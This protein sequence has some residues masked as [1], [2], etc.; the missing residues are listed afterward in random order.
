M[1]KQDLRVFK[2]R[3]SLVEL[4]GKYL[5]LELH[6]SGIWQTCPACNGASK[7]IINND[8]TYKCMQ[9]RCDLHRSGDIFNLF[10][11]KGHSFKEACDILD[12]QCDG[13]TQSRL[14]TDLEEIYE[15]CKIELLKTP[16][17][18]DYISKRYKVTL[19]DLYTKY[20][21][22]GYADKLPKLGFNSPRIVFPI[23]SIDGRLQHLHTRAIDPD[24]P[25]RW[26]P[27]KTGSLGNSTL[28]FAHY[29]WNWQLYR[30]T[31]HLFVTEGISDGLS[32]TKLGLPTVSLLSL[33]GPLDE[34]LNRFTNLESV[35]CVFDNDQVPAG[36]KG[37]YKSWDNLITKLLSYGY[38]N[39]KVKVWCVV[40]PNTIGI[41]DVN[42]WVTHHKLTRDRFLELISRRAKLVTQ[43]T[44]DVY[45]EDYSKHSQLIKCLGKS[46]DNEQ[47]RQFISKV[48]KNNSSWFNYINNLVSGA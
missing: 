31:K 35:V 13:S 32:L 11:W 7:F 16:A 12:I 40:P 21:D 2:A 46:K 4:S 10:A 47:I 5:D 36:E 28:S 37:K 39:P 29:M 14:N 48:N 3:H 9:P 41:K 44:L 6:S 22:I 15:E 43:F 18:I 34:M 38:S 8:R 24:N 1:P 33:M 25:V 26:L 20:Y 17:A 30:E 23:Y 42:D 45:W 19:E 27:T